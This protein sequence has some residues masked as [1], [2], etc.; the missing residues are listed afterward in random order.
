[1]TERCRSVRPTPSRQAQSSSAPT[2]TL[3]LNGFDQ[4]ID[5]LAG[6][7]NVTLGSATLTTGGNNADTT[8]SGVITGTGGLTKVGNGT[9]TLTEVNTYTGDTTIEAG[10]LQAGRDH[11][12]GNGGL[13]VNGGV[14]SLAGFDHGRYFAGG[15]RRYHRFHGFGT[16]HPAG[17]E[18][19]LQ[20]R[21]HGWRRQGPLVIQNTGTLTLG[22][23][24]PVLFRAGV[25][26][27]NTRP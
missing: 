22:G 7:G 5:Q 4:T 6:N 15:Q 8:W 26:R 1:M 12:F 25:A 3:D 17:D 11:A 24:S 16:Q 20:R 10:R 9:L 23:P 13:T 2:R 21:D 14:V 19:H 18:H 27:R